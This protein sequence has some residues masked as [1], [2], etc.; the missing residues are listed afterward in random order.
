MHCAIATYVGL[1]VVEIP[2]IGPV[3]GYGHI[4]A[5]MVG[6]LVVKQHVIVDTVAGVAL[7]ATIFLANVWLF[8][9]L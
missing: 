2:F 6:C 1:I 4:A 8:G 7:G 3:L 9:T 5:T